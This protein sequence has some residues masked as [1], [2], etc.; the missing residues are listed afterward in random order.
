MGIKWFW[1]ILAILYVVSRIDLIPD[2]FAGWG[3][4]DDIVVLVLL[5]R[6]LAG[7]RR[8]RGVFQQNSGPAE[9]A[10]GN[11]HARRHENQSA[12]S[13]TPH[14]ILGLSPGASK[15]GIRSA[16]RRLANQYHPDKVA[17][18]GKEFQDLADQRFKE[19]Q[20]AYR[21]LKG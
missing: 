6:Y 2:V 15:E 4:I 11:S 13:K 17:H 5:Y 18:L 1:I 10:G 16:Y 9:Q 8:G 21:Q 19:I 3:W 14:E 7:I 20:E 12:K